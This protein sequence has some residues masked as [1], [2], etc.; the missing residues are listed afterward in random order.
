MKTRSSTSIISLCL[1]LLVTL[2]CSVDD[3]VDS[4]A[5]IRVEGT[6]LVLGDSGAPIVLRGINLTNQYWWE[7]YEDLMNSID[8]SDADFQRI[9]DMGF[10]CIRF[11]LSY[12]MFVD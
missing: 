10:N 11:A 12:R 6:G 8:H 5:F 1:M 9:A 3:D 4:G 7:S 2:G